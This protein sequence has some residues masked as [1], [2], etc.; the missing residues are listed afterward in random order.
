MNG[1]SQKSESKNK[2]FKV[3][4]KVWYGTSIYTILKFRGFRGKD[5]IIA[6]IYNDATAID[7]WTKDLT[8]IKIAP[9]VANKF[10]DEYDDFEGLPLEFWAKDDPMDFPKDDL[11]CNCILP[12][13]KKDRANFKDYYVC[14][15][16]KKERV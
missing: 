5:D 9:T 13:L 15:D 11:Y 10:G 2:E 1:A 4:Q 6:E 14:L 7:V 12:N 3:G 8:P 16:C